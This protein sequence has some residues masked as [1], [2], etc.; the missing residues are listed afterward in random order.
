MHAMPRSKAHVVEL[1]AAD[2]DELARVVSTGRHPAQMIRRARVL[3][4]LDASQGVVADR[5]VV[6]DRG[7]TA[8][9]TNTSRITNISGNTLLVGPRGSSLRQETATELDEGT[10][11][12]R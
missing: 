5:A 3:L 11:A 2:R 8:E 4:E 12:I 7:K 10:E 1:S 6:A 9:T